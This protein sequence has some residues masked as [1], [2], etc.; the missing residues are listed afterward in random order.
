LIFGLYKF[1][2]CL[3][4]NKF[5]RVLIFIIMLLAISSEDYKRNPSIIL[6]SF[7][8]YSI[9]YNTEFLE[10]KNEDY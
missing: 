7:L 1:C 5:I 3:H 2:C 10:K 6:Y 4:K 9:K 8:G